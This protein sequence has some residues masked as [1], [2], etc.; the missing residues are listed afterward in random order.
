MD[1]NAVTLSRP[2][3]HPASR[4]TLW[5]RLALIVGVLLGL[6]L[7]AQ[8][9]V[10]YY[11]VTRFVIQAELRRDARQ[12]ALSIE[13][14][15]RQ[16]GIFA[17]ADL[18]PV[19]EA[20]RQEAPARIAW[21]RLTDLSGQV[22]AQTGEPGGKPF[23]AERLRRVVEELQPV[24]EVR[25]SPGGD[26]LVSAQPLRIGGRPQQLGGAQRPPG[27]APAAQRPAGEPPAGPRPPGEP[28][29]GPGRRFEPRF[30]EIA[31]YLNSASENF[32]ILRVNLLIAS[33]AALLLLG[34]MT[35]LWLRLPG[36]V[37]GK[38]LER[39]MDL[40]RQVQMGL[41]PDA[42][43][44]LDNLEVAAACVPAQQVGG[45][46]FDVFAAAGG[47]QAMV[48]GD[49]SGKGLPASMMVG[50]VLGA[51]RA[52]DWFSG[53]QDHEDASKRLN[54]LL[55]AHTT[56]ERFA[57]LVWCYYQPAERQLCCVNAGHL[58]PIVARRGKDGS[59]EIQRL[60]ASGPVLGVLP[61]AR[62]RQD[63]VTLEP[64]DLLVLYSDGV[65]EA[66]NAAEE[67]FEEDRLLEVIRQQYDK[68]PAQIRDEILAQV[69]A[70]EA[71]QPPQ[72]DIT[73]VVARVVEP[74][75]PAAGG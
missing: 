69:E 20:V 26:V 43:H 17:Y 11:Q 57:S 75:P 28:G 66:E 10:N 27:E 44:R 42:D 71:G 33:S 31:V 18:K 16:Q 32:G 60:H 29:R 14:E 6:L 40:A 48:V 19:L 4:G 50:L 53:A 8:S 46:F 62:Y 55:Y 3:Q 65:V 9:I 36:Y 51:V 56:P 30:L 12:F 61:E 52:S 1:P 2:V 23:P 67:L 35:L 37:R 68:H 73:L 5:L 70:F 25:A 64:G 63:R 7:L 13:R 74:G 24:S 54:E 38:Q 72:D 15:A 22:L 59:V 34:S 21:I 41:L 58:A 49:V 47:R 45:D 39:Q